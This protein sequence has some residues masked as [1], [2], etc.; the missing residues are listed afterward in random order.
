MF[1]RFMNGQVR[2][3]APVALPGAAAAELEPMT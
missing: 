1:R 2:P 3:V